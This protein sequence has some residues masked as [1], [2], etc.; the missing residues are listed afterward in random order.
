M[1]AWS[2]AEGPRCCGTKVPGVAFQASGACSLR[3]SFPVDRRRA[4]GLTAR[5]TPQDPSPHAWGRNERGAVGR[6]AVDEAIRDP[7]PR[8]RMQLEHECGDIASAKRSR[9][10][11]KRRGGLE[12][13]HLGV[14]GRGWGEPGRSIGPGSPSYW[15]Y[16]FPTPGW[17]SDWSQ[18]RPDA[19][20]SFLVGWRHRTVRL[21]PVERARPRRVRS[22]G[23][24]SAH[25]RPCPS[26]LR[27]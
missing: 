4:G 11:P 25:S 18:H 15:G 14:S 6:N 16:R 7:L 3:C 22:L 8:L 10:R 24:T 5:A 23:R 27:A 26:A 17:R 19:R 12:A 21:G 20:E 9:G 13:A 1:H 2:P